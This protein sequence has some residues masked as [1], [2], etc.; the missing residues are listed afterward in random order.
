MSHRKSHEK[1]G[2]SGIMIFID[3]GCEGLADTAEHVSAGGSCQAQA[4]TCHNPLVSTEARQGV[5]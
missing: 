3:I 2:K 5:V 4:A 1:Q